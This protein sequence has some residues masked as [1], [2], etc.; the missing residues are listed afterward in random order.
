MEETPEEES[1]MREYMDANTKRLVDQLFK[2]DRDT[3][4]QILIENMTTEL[5][6]SLRDRIYE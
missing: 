1:R 6:Y 3:A 4:R 2:L 5:L